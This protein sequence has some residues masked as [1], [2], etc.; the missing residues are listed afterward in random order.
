MQFE[1]IFVLNIPV[2]LFL[3]LL[4]EFI[5]NELLLDGC[6]DIGPCSIFFSKL[7][8]RGPLDHTLK[9]TILVRPLDVSELNPKQ[10]GCQSCIEN[11]P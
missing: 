11:G 4:S 10:F 7:F 6:A 3:L 2:N 8:V 9:K 1:D 5:F